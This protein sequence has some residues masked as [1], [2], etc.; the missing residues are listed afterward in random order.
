[1]R[2]MTWRALSISPHQRPCG[3]HGAFAD[4]NVPQDCGVSSDE[5]ALSDLGV[6]AHV[7]IAN[8]V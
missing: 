3:D 4:G 2:L 8:K 5:D 7:E 6:A 1:M